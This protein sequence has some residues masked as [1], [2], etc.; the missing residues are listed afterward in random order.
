LA[1][2]VEILA[3]ELESHGI[4]VNGF[5][6]DGCGTPDGFARAATFVLS[7][8]ASSFTGNVITI[9]AEDRTG[10]LAGVF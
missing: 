6:A 8:A 4:R 1:T 2:A 5:I 9:D 3:E 10:H 7:P